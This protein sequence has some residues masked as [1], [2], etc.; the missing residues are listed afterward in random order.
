MM[1]IDDND[2]QLIVHACTAIKHT[3]STTHEVILDLIINSDCL[4]KLLQIMNRTDNE[5]II[6]AGIHIFGNI[7]T[8]SDQ[9]TQQLIEVGVCPILRQNIDHQNKAIQ[10]YTLW[11]ISNISAGTSTQIQ[12]IIDSD[13]VPKIF[14]LF[15]NESPINLQQEAMWVIS[16]IASTGVHPQVLYLVELG[17]I[18]VC[19][20]V[21][22]GIGG[23]L[24]LT[25]LALE[26]I[27]S[28][29]AWAKVDPTRF[30]LVID[31]IHE[32][33]MKDRIEFLSESKSVDIE[34]AAV[35]ILEE[36]DMHTLSSEQ[37]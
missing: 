14:Q 19:N 18:G 31:Q 26:T 8:G 23:T 33:E 28:I 7:S 34:S 16:N 2:D 37:S 11:T 3:S 36:I 4:P 30:K 13:I 25:L 21:L 5:E 6:L 35:L 22:E 9:Q 17:C 27:L 32:Y 15:Q 10:K 12:S 29:L 1:S 24:R 20:L